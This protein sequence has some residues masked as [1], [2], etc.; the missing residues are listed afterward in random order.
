[1]YHIL[2]GE[3]EF[4]R[5][6]QV[7]ALRV[8]Q[9]DPQFADLNCV[10]FDGRK[11]TLGELVHACDAIPFLAAGRLVIVEGMLARL[12]PRQRKGGEDGEEE[13]EEEVNPDLAGGLIEYLARLPASTELVF[14]ESKTLAKN[15]P[16]V[17]FAAGDKKNGKIVEFPLPR[18]NDLPAWIERRIQS[19]GGRADA[20]VAQE[21]AAHVGADLRLLD[22]EIDKL[23][24]YR[25]SEPIQSED[26][27]SLVASVREANIF[28]LVDAIGARQTN[29]A[30][31]LLHD[32]LDQNAAPLYLLTM[33][34]RQFRLLLQIKDLAGRGLNPAAMREQTRLH[35]FV[36]DKVSK[37][38]ANFS[39]PQLEAIYDQ[40]LDTDL[41][42]KTGR[43]DPVVALDLLVV[44][45]TQRQA[46]H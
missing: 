21:L 33:V 38:A 45:L 46:A 15:N 10:T 8:A 30:M 39:M 22:N 32:H 16:V 36:I 28:E 42:I 1:M 18:V 35:P 11:V 6:E 2:H 29:V 20:R 41:A 26:V 13:T 4:S 44:A 17:K 3:D 27:R 12:D 5:T 25:G 14:A 34:V 23:L 19:K 37:Q 43:S 7:N 24:A 31:R 9:G 40:L